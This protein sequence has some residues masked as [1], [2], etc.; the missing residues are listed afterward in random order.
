MANVNEEYAALVKKSLRQK[1]EDGLYGEFKLFGLPL[2]ERQYRFHKERQWRVD[3]CWPSLKIIVEVQGGIFIPAGKGGH[4][5]G[6]YMEKEYEKS[7]EATKLG[8]S[9]YKFGP[10]ACYIPK[11]MGQSSAALNFLYPLLHSPEPGRV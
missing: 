10:K 5:R 11:R 8:W 7:N 9:V 3:F 2:P 6:G 4:N 1:L